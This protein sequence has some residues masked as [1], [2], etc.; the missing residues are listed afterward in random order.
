MQVA[1][2]SAFLRDLKRTRSK[3][4]RLRVQQVIQ[5]VK[6]ASSPL[7]IVSLTKL[8]GYERFYRIR[9][10]DY[11][12]GIEIVEDTVIFVRFLHRRDIYR[13]FP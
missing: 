1:Y 4:I 10:G 2:E 8:R 13:Y 6:T 12:L 9:I 11:R 3:N 7:D 5:D